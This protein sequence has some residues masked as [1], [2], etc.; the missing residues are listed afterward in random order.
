MRVVAA[1][2]ELLAEVLYLNAARV[3]GD[4]GTRGASS[5]GKKPAKPR[6]YSGLSW[7]EQNRNNELCP[8]SKDVSMILSSVASA[9]ERVLRGRNLSAV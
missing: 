2:E 9:E 3:C 4:G 6:G 8:L 7:G 5:G 1:V